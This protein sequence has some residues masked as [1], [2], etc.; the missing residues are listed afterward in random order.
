MCQFHNIKIQFGTVEQ[1]YNIGMYKFYRYYIKLIIKE[2]MG[3]TFVSP[4]R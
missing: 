4:D 3:Y 2:L 1:N